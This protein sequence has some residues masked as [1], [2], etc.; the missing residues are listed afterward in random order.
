MGRRRTPATGLDRGSAYPPSLVGATPGVANRSW[1]ALAAVDTRQRRWRPLLLDEGGAV[2]RRSALV[3]SLRGHT[4]GAAMMR[5]RSSRVRG[6]R[7]PPRRT[8]GRSAA[9]PTNAGTRSATRRLGA[10]GEIR[11][12]AWS[13]EGYASLSARKAIDR[14]HGMRSHLRRGRPLRPGGCGRRWVAVLLRPPALHWGRSPSY[15]P[16]GGTTCAVRPARARR[17]TSSPVSSGCQVATAR[18]MEGPSAK[19][20]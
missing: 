1:Q 14:R 18:R 8:N 6:D 15:G 19:W 11:T 9:W 7:E 2:S 3:R 5:S 12:E 17:I 13:P 16:R 4:N 20:S 10:Y